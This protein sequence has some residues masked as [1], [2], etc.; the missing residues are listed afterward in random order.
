MPEEQKRL[1]EQQLWN[2]ANELRG[3]MSADEFRNYILGFIFYK[4]ETSAKS[5]NIN[6]QKMLKEVK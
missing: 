5:S 2:I 3:K 4:Y 6:Y 1:L